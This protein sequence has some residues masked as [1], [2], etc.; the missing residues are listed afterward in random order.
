MVL[1]SHCLKTL[2][3]AFCAVFKGRWVFRF[4]DLANFWFGFSIPTLKLRFL[5]FWCLVF[6][7]L[8]FGSVFVN[9][10][11]GFSDFSIPCILRFYWSCQESYTLQ[12]AKIVI[13]ETTYIA[14][15][16]F[17]QRDR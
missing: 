10:D 7:N 8:V 2:N 13:Q 14:F 16:P 11:G 1:P 9:I 6:S 5:Q 3:N 15:H 17:F 4:A 12:C